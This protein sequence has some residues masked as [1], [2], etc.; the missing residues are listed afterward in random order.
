M[1]Y[2]SID[3]G[4]IDDVR[5]LRAEVECCR[6]HELGDERYHQG[7]LRV[8][9]M[10]REASTKTRWQWPRAGGRILCFLTFATGRIF[11]VESPPCLSASRNRHLNLS[12]TRPSSGSIGCPART[13]PKYG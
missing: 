3:D 12:D 7:L 11:W 10:A 2:T 6:R 13:T 8:H 9:P 4:R 1:A 5:K